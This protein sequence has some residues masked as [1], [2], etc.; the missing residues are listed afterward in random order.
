MPCLWSCSVSTTAPFSITAR[1]SEVESSVAR[2]IW[3]AVCS[4]CVHSRCRSSC[5]SLLYALATQ[6]L[7]ALV[8]A[9][10]ALATICVPRK[11][12]HGDELGRAP[13]KQ[14]VVLHHVLRD[15]RTPHDALCARRAPPAVGRPRRACGARPV[16]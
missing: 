5:R 3:K 13:A 14:E 9:T 10:F 16:A 1:L 6:F 8:F 12:S 7:L 11:H 4:S 15:S 2:A